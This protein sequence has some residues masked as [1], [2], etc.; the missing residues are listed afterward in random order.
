MEWWCV[1]L[2]QERQEFDSAVFIGG[3]AM[4]GKTLLKDVLISGGAGRIAGAL[5]DVSFLPDELDPDRATLTDTVVIRTLNAAFRHHAR[6]GETWL[7]DK[8][9]QNLVRARLLARTI[10]NARH[11]FLIRHPAVCWQKHQQG[12]FPFDRLFPDFVTFI[13]MWL[14]WYGVM[15]SDCERLRTPWLVVRFEAMKADLV[16]E[17]SRVGKFLGLSLAV[18]QKVYG[19]ERGAVED[20]DL[21]Y[22]VKFTEKWQPWADQ[23]GKFGYLFQHPWYG[24]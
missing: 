5:G 16:G 23:V 6:C 17:V 11:L 20:D 21:S 7:A 9:P 3:W 12:E 19:T 1:V 15:Q 13:T 22:L 4:T 10:R 24:G 18:P 2:T 14:K 8:T